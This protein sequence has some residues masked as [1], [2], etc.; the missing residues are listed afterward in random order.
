MLNRKKPKAAEF[1]LLRQI[2]SPQFYFKPH[3]SSKRAVVTPLLLE[4]K[5]IAMAEERFDFVVFGATGFTGQFVVDEV[6]RVIEE[7]GGSMKFA[8]AGRTMDKL[9]KVLKESSVRTGR[10]NFCKILLPFMSLLKTN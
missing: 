9:Q 4:K 1:L 2:D 6:A 5:K 7:Q 3:H 10:A 8:V